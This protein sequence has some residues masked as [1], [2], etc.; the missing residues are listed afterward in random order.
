MSGDE[1]T[2]CTPVLDGCGELLAGRIQALVDQLVGVAEMLKMGIAPEAYG[3]LDKHLAK[4]GAAG[5][6]A[7]DQYAEHHG[8]VSGRVYSECVVE[9]MEQVR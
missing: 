7:L 6:Y 8:E 4:C 5:Q 1:K 3:E 2:P 9:F